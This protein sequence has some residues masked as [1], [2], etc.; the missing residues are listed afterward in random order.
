MRIVIDMQGAQSP[1]S[2]TRGIG[3]YTRALINA[4]INNRKDHE[5]ILV[6]NDVF[7]ETADEIRKQFSS[8]IGEKNILCWNSLSSTSFADETNDARR[9][10]CELKRELFISTLNPDFLLITSLFEGFQ[11]DA[12]TSIGL[13]HRNYLIATILYDLIP[14]V[15]H[16]VYLPNKRLKTWYLEKLNHFKRSDLFFGI[17]ESAS[18]EAVDLL[19]VSRSRVANISTDADEQFCSIE[20][21]AHDE[22]R[23]R[24]RYN[25]NGRFIMYTGGIDF[26]KNI[27]GLIK[28]YSLLPPSLRKHYQ[29]AIVC[30]VQPE[31][32]KRLQDLAQDQGL[33]KG[34]VVFTNY[35]SDEELV[36]LYN[37]CYLFVFPSWHEGFGLPALEAMRCKAPVIGSN[38]SSIP[39]IIQLEEAL[40]DPHSVKSISLLIEKALVDKSFRERLIKNSILKSE[41]FDWNKSA[42]RA[43]EKLEQ[44][45]HNK[46]LYLALSNNQPDR[47]RMAYI[48]PLPPQ[49]S[50]IANYSAELVRHLSIYY[51]IDLVCDQEVAPD[52]YLG[53]LRLI[54]VDQFRNDYKSYDR[55]IYHFGNSVFH[56][57]MF[58]LL[59]EV[60]GI[61]VLHDF[62]LSGVLHYMQASTTNSFI[63]DQALFDSHGYRALRFKQ[64]SKEIIDVIMK[65]PSNI[66][67]LQNAIGIITHSLYAKRLAEKLYTFTS[68][69][70]RVIPLLRER[71]SKIDKAEARQ[72]LGIDNRSFV[73]CSFGI[74]GPTKLSHK[75]I[76]AWE[77]S[78][79][80]KADHC[81]LVYVGEN[82]QGDYGRDL[83]VMTKKRANNTAYITGWVDDNEYKLYLAAAD[84][85]VQLRTLSRGETSAAILDCMSSGIPVIANAHGTTAEISNQAIVMLEDNFTSDDLSEA[86]NSLYR[87]K[88]KREEI[89]KTAMDL[90]ASRHLPINCAALYYSAIEDFY[91]APS[92]TDHYI[93]N[94]IA[95]LRHNL[96]PSSSDLLDISTIYATTMPQSVRLCQLLIDVSSIVT[97]G[98]SD[99]L[100]SELSL[101]TKRLILD[102]SHQFNT[103]PI[104]VTDND[105]FIYAR[106][107]TK[108]LLGIQ[109][110]QL[111]DEPISYYSG[112]ILFV[113]H[114]MG[115]QN[116]SNL[117]S[118]KKLSEAGIEIITNKAVLAKRIGIEML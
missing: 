29:L 41:L 8:R 104:Y 40:F 78:E 82:H 66:H 75:L 101:L 49:R 35:V 31:T 3:R 102:E 117:S 97:H 92:T 105:C 12:V 30:S 79:L 33:G 10:A 87:D 13:S 86:I 14:L 25:I 118:Y 22:H 94:R 83:E 47:R 19:R 28:A 96:K 60:P 100:N 18:K 91:K 63:F 89:A 52:A 39:E 32:L 90:I 62:F 85:A 98:T 77:K 99:L 116:L 56:S 24:T 93:V 115:S 15:N 20:V 23:V 81:K 84:I 68:D 106:Q 34:D 114:S 46:D 88:Q 9:T 72:R 45:I 17:S 6:L 103:Q 42:K 2:A 5:V 74:I 76:E 37:I 57:Y 111:L 44:E 51:D 70:W 4:I 54:P 26:R 7:T 53:E 113:N 110:N 36:V 80:G 21:S 73:V 71:N 58:E 112:D 108:Q 95:S 11:D 59:T 38:S 69:N 50:G 48:S 43:I 55:V 1:S 16:Q 107:Y 67:V 64:A 61:V 109:G 27:D 65:Y